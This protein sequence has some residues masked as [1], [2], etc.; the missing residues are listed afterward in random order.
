MTQNAMSAYQIK[1][2]VKTIK[3]VQDWDGYLD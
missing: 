2:P 1:A 3:L